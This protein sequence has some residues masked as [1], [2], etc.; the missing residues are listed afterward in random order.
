MVARPSLVNLTALFVA[1]AAIVGLLPL[2]ADL[3]WGPVIAHPFPSQSE[4]VLAGIRDLL[5]CSSLL[6]AFFMWL[7]RPVVAVPLSVAAVAIAGLTVLSP[8]LNVGRYMYSN[9][10]FDPASSALEAAFPWVFLAALLLH[11][12]VCAGFGE[13]LRIRFSVRWLLIVGA[14]HVGLF[15]A[16][17]SAI[18]YSPNWIE[19]FLTLPGHLFVGLLIRFRAAGWLLNCSSHSVV[20][21]L[22]E[23]FGSTLVWSCIFAFIGPRIWTSR[24]K[25][26]SQAM[27]RTAPR[28]NV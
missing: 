18:S 9:P 14:A 7:Q 13:P 8:L 17:T 22:I 5:F 27:Q 2:V 4:R 26:S 15:I 1:A 6:L 11:P 20:L 24:R 3:L 21:P 25:P 28:S 23:V 19:T 10:V 12:T 16:A